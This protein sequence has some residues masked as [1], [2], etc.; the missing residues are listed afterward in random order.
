MRLP[1]RHNGADGMIHVNIRFQTINRGL[2]EEIYT[3][4]I[5]WSLS[6][7]HINPRFYTMWNLC[8]KR[9]FLIFRAGNVPIQHHQGAGTSPDNPRFHTRFT[10]YISHLYPVQHIITTEMSYCIVLHER[11]CLNKWAP[12]TPENPHPS[13]D[14]IHPKK[15]QTGE[16]C[17]KISRLFIWASWLLLSV[18]QC[19]ESIYSAL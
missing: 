3:M 13:F 19:A 9:N 7:F 12:S 16:N 15:K 2:K 10:F 1:S 17:L 18:C 5:V 11:S 14:G 6:I 4:S 8:L